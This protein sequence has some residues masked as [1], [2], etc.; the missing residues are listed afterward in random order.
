MIMTVIIS[1]L[2]TSIY[3][4]KIG[5]AFWSNDIKMFLIAGLGMVFMTIFLYA[6]M[7]STSKFIERIKKK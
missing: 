5:D 3:S 2:V 6:L 4:Q 7:I 1:V